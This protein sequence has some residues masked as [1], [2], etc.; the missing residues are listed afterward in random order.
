MLQAC[1][2]F[3]DLAQSQGQKWQKMLHHEKNQRQRLEEIIEQLAR[4]QN[5]LE[6]AAKTHQMH[7]THDLHAS[8]SF[9]DVKNP[10]AR[11]LL[12]RFD[13]QLAVMKEGF[14]SQEMLVG[15]TVE[16]SEKAKGVEE[17]TVDLHGANAQGAIA[18]AVGLQGVKG[19]AVDPQGMIALAVSLQEANAKATEEKVKGLLDKFDEQLTELEEALKTQR[20][21][22][23]SIRRSSKSVEYAQAFAKN[24]T[25]ICNVLQICRGIPVGKYKREM[26]ISLSLYYID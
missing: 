2:E 18:Q 22:F 20:I 3:L 15:R 5:I 9:A 12:E 23:T 24:V 8:K 11:E 17:H 6:Q 25:G 13:R 4:Q 14:K 7:T 21:K 16:S 10:K 26:A 19:Q 1:S